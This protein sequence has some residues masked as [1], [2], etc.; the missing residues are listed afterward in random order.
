MTEREIIIEILNR[1]PL[2]INYEDN[3]TIEFENGYGHED[4]NIDFDEDGNVI[5]IYC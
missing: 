3:K 5:D 1:I 2:K 4:I